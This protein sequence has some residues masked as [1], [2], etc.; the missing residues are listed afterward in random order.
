MTLPGARKE[1]GR[2]LAQGSEAAEREQ[3]AKRP[4]PAL[5]VPGTGDLAGLLG[6]GGRGPSGGTAA[7]SPQSCR[8]LASSPQP[9]RVALG[10]LGCTPRPSLGLASTVLRETG[11]PI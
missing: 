5:L 10:A 11:G 2:V 3:V 4:E 7:T 6:G 9:W 8:A 1:E